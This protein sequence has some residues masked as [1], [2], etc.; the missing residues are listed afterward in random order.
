MRVS[1]VTCVAHDIQTL[2][3]LFVPEDTKNY[4]YNKNK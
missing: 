3:Y 1:I 2:K 4:Q